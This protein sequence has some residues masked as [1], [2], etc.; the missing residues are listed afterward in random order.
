MATK[1][2]R[3]KKTAKRSFDI[4]NIDL[5]KNVDVNI[6]YDKIKETTQDVNEFILETSEDIVDGAIKRG[7]EWQGVANKAVKGGL[8]LAANQ[9]NIVFD[10]LETLKGQ[11]I[12][13]RKRFKVLFSKN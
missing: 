12:D 9:Q 3:T 11:F 1:S 4:K 5:L 2:T 6:S 10:T 13:G 8:K 7:N